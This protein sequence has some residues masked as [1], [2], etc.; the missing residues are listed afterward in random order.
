MAITQVLNNRILMHCEN[1]EF[2]GLKS[3]VFPETHF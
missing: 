2:N 3:F 1:L